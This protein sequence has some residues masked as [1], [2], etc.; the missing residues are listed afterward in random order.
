MKY[1]FNENEKQIRST[2]V[3]MS[4]MNFKQLSS[5]ADDALFELYPD[6]DW[7]FE[8]LSSNCNISEDIV[9]KYSYKPWNLLKLSVKTNIKHRFDKYDAKIKNQLSKKKKNKCN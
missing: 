2:S 1:F 9:I 4:N 8:A 7:D 6:A 5:T 3:N